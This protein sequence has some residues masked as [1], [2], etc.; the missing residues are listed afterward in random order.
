MLIDNNGLKKIFRENGIPE[1]LCLPSLTS[2][3][4]IDQIDRCLKSDAVYVCN[5]DGI[6]DKCTMFVLGYLMAKKQEIF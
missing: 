4:I 2:N 5:S 3:D 1:L 6:L